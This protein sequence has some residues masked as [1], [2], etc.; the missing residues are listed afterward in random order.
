MAQLAANAADASLTAQR[1]EAAF[2]PT[3]G[4]TL[5]AA[6][7]LTLSLGGY[8]VWHGSLSIGQ[9]TSFSMYLGQL[10]WPMF[11][12]G[13]VL[14]LLERGKAA[15]ARLDPIL[16]APLTVDDHGSQGTVPGGTL[17]L[18]EVGFSYPQ[19][20]QAALDGVSL[21]LPAGGVLALVG[22]TGS[23]KSTLLKLLLRQYHP[24]V[25]RILWQGQALD[26]YTL[27]ALRRA[28]SW[29][30][31]EAFLFSASVADNIALVKPRCQPRRYRARG[32]AGRRAR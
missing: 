6:S 10:I 31:Q 5:T 13:W 18:D 2:E 1:W 14:A 28:I 21:Q 8:L 23:G 16:S 11:A 3:V 15:W 12:A 29:V 20:A 19:Q 32:A 24:K 9:L 17:Q 27:N 25:G 4:M 30:P 26:D 22:P 7:V